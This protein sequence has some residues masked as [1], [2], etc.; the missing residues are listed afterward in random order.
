[1]F[2]ND[3]IMRLI[4]DIIRALKKLIFKTEAENGEIVEMGALVDEDLKRLSALIDDGKINEAENLLIEKME[5]ENTKTFQTALLFYE[6][7][8]FKSDDFLED[9]DFSRREIS[10]GLKYA[11]GLYGYGSMIDALLAN[12]AED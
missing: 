2:Q 12:D 5:K 8:N 1:M 10:E 9:N 11:A 7:L 3:Y 4:Y 6:Y